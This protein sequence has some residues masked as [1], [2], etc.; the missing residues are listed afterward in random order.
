M[1]FHVLFFISFC[2]YD[3][4]YDNAGA[5]DMRKVTVLYYMND[6]RPELG[7]CFR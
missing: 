7:G 1:F 4:H 3:Q 2:Y 5:E 6:W